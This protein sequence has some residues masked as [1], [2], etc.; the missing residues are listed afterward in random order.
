MVDLKEGHQFTLDIAGVAEDAAAKAL[1]RKRGLL[2]RILSG[3]S[4]GQI[5]DELRRIED[6][7]K[8]GGTRESM[9]WYDTQ[10]GRREV[11]ATPEDLRFILE[12]RATTAKNRG[13]H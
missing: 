12:Q 11:L 5:L 9:H 3:Q 6:N 10:G 8:A 13:H 7:F 2:T 4:N 1:A